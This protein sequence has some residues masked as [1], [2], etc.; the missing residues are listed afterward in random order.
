FQLAAVKV[1]LDGDT[2]PSFVLELLRPM[3]T[4]LVGWELRTTLKLAVPPA[5]VVTS[6]EV[7][8]TVMPGGG[9]AGVVAKL[10][11]SSR[12]PVTVLPAS[13]GVLLAAPRMAFLICRAVAPG[14]VA[15]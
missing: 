8:V 1:R 4:L 3:V 14:C 6:P 10:L 13:D 11:R 7:G 2:V 5:S 15:A 12:P 9:T